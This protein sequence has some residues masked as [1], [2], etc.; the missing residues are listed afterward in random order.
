MK[1]W[2]NLQAD[3][4]LLMNKHYT[5]GRAGRSIN[6][7]RVA[8]Q[9]RTAKYSRLLERMANPPSERSLPS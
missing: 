9:R 4:N 2:N 1:D 8:P 6:T 5:P 3:Q 7:N